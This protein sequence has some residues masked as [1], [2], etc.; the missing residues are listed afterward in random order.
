MR[1][2]SQSVPLHLTRAALMAL[3]RCARPFGSA[4]RYGLTFGSD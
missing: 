4:G 2:I 1:V 3:L